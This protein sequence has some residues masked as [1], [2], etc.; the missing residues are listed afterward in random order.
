M[1]AACAMCTLAFVETPITLGGR[2]TRIR[3][4]LARTSHLPII[5]LAD[6]NWS[7]H[8]QSSAVR[9]T[10]E[11]TESTGEESVEAAT[12]APAQAIASP[13]PTAEKMTMK[14]NL[15]FVGYIGA[16]MAFFYAVAF[17]FKQLI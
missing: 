17:V 15:I 5:R 7:G 3:Q 8:I 14:D 6:A 10:I 2:S 11:S 4:V 16:F 13:E 12:P 9:M 1:L